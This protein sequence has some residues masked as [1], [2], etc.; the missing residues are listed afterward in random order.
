MF[1]ILFGLG[2]D[3]DVFGTIVDAFR[4]MF[5]TLDKVVYTLIGWVYNLL[6][7]I[8]DV[9]ILEASVL[10]DFYRRVRLILGVIMIFKI[11][12]SLMQ[13][14]INPDAFGDKKSGFGKVVS[15]IIIMTVMLTTLM[16]LSIPENKAP[17]DS[18][19]AYLNQHGLLFGT[20]YS[21]QHRILA[22]NTIF[23]L[24]LGREDGNLPND[25][26][27]E[28][29]V[30]SFSVNST[31]GERVATY[32][33]KGFIT[34]NLRP[35]SDGS[36]TYIDDKLEDSDYMC[37][38]SAEVRDESIL[39]KLLMANIE[40]FGWNIV[41]PF[42]GTIK[43]GF[44][45][46]SEYSTSSNK[47]GYYYNIWYKATTPEEILQLVNVSC[48]EDKLY[49]FSYFPIISTICGAIL[50]VLICGYCIDVAIRT[51][52]L[53]ILQLLAPIAIIS[54]IDPKSS[55]KGSFASW[56]R[57]LITTYV[58]LFL[59][60][61]IFAFI[62]FICVEVTNGGLN[63]ELDSVYKFF[64]NIFIII[65]LFF[66]ARM[67]PKFITDALGIKGMGFGVGISG[68]F[69]AAG[70]VM[71][72]GGLA[73]AAAGFLE[74][75]DA[76]ADAAAQGKQAPSA[77]N[78]QRDKIAKLITGDK[79][80]KG[81]LI[82]GLT[83]TANDVA[84]A[85]LAE[86]MFG[87]NRNKVAAAK[88]LKYAMAAEAADAKNKY[89]RYIH[90]SMSDIELQDLENGE[91]FDNFLADKGVSRADYDT[92]L[93][94]DQKRALLT[95]ALESDW[96]SKETASAKQN[97]W[98]EEGAKMLESLGINE[99]LQ[100][101][102]SARGRNRARRLYDQNLAPQGVGRQYKINHSVR[103]KTTINRADDIDNLN[104]P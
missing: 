90:G 25:E 29:N 87:I 33:L 40:N 58:D 86:R 37:P 84:N 45:I 95:E 14:V 70:A 92:L 100:E 17:K 73:G 9:S 79:N 96:S 55:E 3:T 75:A 41:I 42:G 39:K 71:G 10:K 60:L 99:T 67:A 102:Y 81:G 21:L 57:L 23:K 12:I 26:Y 32:M 53:T 38:P 52:K 31:I 56:T 16:P 7:S 61:A 98:Y 11:S 34:I 36:L 94:A 93:N 47:M 6:F 101:K 48:K 8:A 62:S 22:N 77:Y 15:R 104:N 88:D 2:Y 64:A 82:G 35:K 30:N 97:A 49:G 50:L 63:L 28:E 65:G 80:A 68:I 83:R 59:H 78:T 54:Y 72:G 4:T 76:A 91:M 74:S 5:A 19:N 44:D 46:M 85:N 1:Q 18:Y 13:Y 69:G 66:F 103:P 89:E 27:N 51:L 20:L 43:S 24:V